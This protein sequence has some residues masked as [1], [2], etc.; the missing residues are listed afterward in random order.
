MIAVTPCWRVPCPQ[1]IAPLQAG[2]S[3][4]RP[5]IEM[6]IPS[7]TDASLAPPGHHVALLF[8]QWAPYH[9]TSHGADGGVVSCDWKYERE[10]FAK[11][12]FEVIEAHAPGFTASIVGFEVL[13]PPDLE[14]VF[15][16]PGG[17][18]CHTAMTYD[19]LLWMRPVP[20]YA[21]YNTPIRGLWQG[22]AGCHP[23]G[24]VMGAAGYNAAQEILRH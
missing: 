3:S 4:T 23:G 9:L 2:R 6:T 8:C 1:S 15:G 20:G 21:R 17:N 7:V 19:Q 14:S 12:V 5:V 24:G 13:A 10:A 16:L 11:R 18:I 22:G